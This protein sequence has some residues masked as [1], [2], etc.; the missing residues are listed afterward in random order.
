MFFLLILPLVEL[1]LSK[2]GLPVQEGFRAEPLDDAIIPSVP[3]PEF[4]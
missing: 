4:G 2:Y 1:F 3:L